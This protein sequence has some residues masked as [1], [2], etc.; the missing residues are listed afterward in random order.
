VQEYKDE[1]KL[2]DEDYEEDDNE[3]EEEDPIPPTTPLTFQ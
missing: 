3:E 2:M 1:L